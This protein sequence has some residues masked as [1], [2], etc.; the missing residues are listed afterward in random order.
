MRTVNRY[1][2]ILVL[3]VHRLGTLKSWPVKSNLQK[4]AFPIILVRQSICLTLTCK[5][6]LNLFDMNGSHIIIS[7]KARK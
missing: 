3:L 5:N 1:Y 2:F 4:I 6:F 7:F